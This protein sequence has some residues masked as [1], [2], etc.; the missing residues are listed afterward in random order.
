M[1]DEKSSLDRLVVAW[2]DVFRNQPLTVQQ[3]LLGALSGGDRTEILRDLLL[4]IAPSVYP[5]VCSTH[6]LGRWLARSV[7][8][9]IIVGCD[10]YNFVD[11]GNL[12]RGRTWQLVPRVVHEYRDEDV[13][14]E[15]FYDEV[16]AG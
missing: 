8:K 4:E 6:K 3:L 12:C 5:G 11:R 16:A 9:K 14:P 1:L 2:W 13:L 15:G 7:G 10:E